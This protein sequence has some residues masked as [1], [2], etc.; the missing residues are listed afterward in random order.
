M[1]APESF[2]KKSAR[3]EAQAKAKAAAA[4]QAAKDAAAME[5]TIT[6]KAAA[7][8]AEYEAAERTA[9]D[10][11][12]A[13]KANNQI[14][15]PAEPKVYFVV[16]VRGTIGVSPKVKKILQLLRLRQIHNGV[17]VKVN[18][19]TINMLRLIEPY[20]AY[21]A[22]NLKSVRELMY[23]R[24]F[25]KVNGQRIPLSSNAVISDVLG[26]NDIVC[27]EDLIHEIFTCGDNF[28]AANNFIW[29]FKLPSPKGGFDGKML[30]HHNEDGA[31]GNQGTKINR[32]IKKLM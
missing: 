26:A 16:R 21:G 10:N 20:I 13:A 32:L 18:A 14:Y 27:M 1:S 23:K 12:R 30:N 3:N 19:A 31:C 15:V 4:A 7:Y 29:P 28:K 2:K 8:E 17:F 11:R 9:I 22:P 5:K 6:A 24:G 25:G